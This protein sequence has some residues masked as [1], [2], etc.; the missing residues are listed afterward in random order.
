V[1]DHYTL[2][3][4]QTG[5]DLVS[6]RY[7]SDRRWNEGKKFDIPV[8]GSVHGEYATV[9]IPYD[10]DLPVG[11]TD[12]IFWWVDLTNKNGTTT[13]PQMVFRVIRE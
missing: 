6:F 11:A 3:V 2:S 1:S 7:H 8:K 4:H 13:P 12:Y 5:A 9:N 10:S